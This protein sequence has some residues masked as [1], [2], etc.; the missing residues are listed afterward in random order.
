MVCV[1]S[2]FLDRPPLDRSVF[3]SVGTLSLNRFLANLHIFEP[4][5]G[6]PDLSSTIKLAK[7][8]FFAALSHLFDGGKLSA[9]INS[10]LLGNLD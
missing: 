4:T 10:N 1:I 6:Q 8:K 7:P 3:V 5:Q 2:Q 9:I